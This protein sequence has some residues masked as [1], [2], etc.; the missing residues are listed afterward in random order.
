MSFSFPI[1]INKSAGA[2]G[3]AF[4]PASLTGLSIN[5]EVYF[6]NNTDIP[7]WPGLIALSGVANVQNDYF[8]QFQ[9]APHTP[10]TIWTASSNDTLTYANSLDNSA[11]PPTGTIVVAAPVAAPTSTI[12]SKEPS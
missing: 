12:A 7:Q 8:M 1:E 5:D 9:I 6:I 10:S 2:S 4:S 3:Y 11:T